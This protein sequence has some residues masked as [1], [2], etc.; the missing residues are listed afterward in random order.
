MSEVSVRLLG[1]DIIPMVR[2]YDRLVIGD[3][4]VKELRKKNKSV[5]MVGFSSR[6]RHLAP[7]GEPD[8]EI[9]GLNRIHQQD[10]FPKN[11]DRMFQLHPIKYLQKSI[12]CVRSTISH[13]TVR[14]HIKN[15]RPLSNF[16]SNAY[17]QS[18]GTSTHQ[19][20]HI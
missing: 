1:Q 18:M 14:K 13:S 16:L 2:S 4:Q 10:W 9:W 5:A 19:L 17:G 20:W 15:F 8:I 7:F 6:H 3:E 12:G 11:P